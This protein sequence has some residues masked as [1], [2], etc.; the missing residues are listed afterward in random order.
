M[1]TKVRC[2]I[3]PRVII[4][5]KDDVDLMVVKLV[6]T[7]AFCSS[8]I[9]FLCILVLSCAFILSSLGPSDPCPY[10]PTD[11]EVALRRSK[12]NI[13]YVPCVSFQALRCRLLAQP[14]YVST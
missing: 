13:L 9:R 7:V 10:L 11:L 14:G 1:I 5:N 8:S 3:D 4:R 12:W 6:K 2:D